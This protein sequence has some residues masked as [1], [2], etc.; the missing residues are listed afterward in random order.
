MCL[1]PWDGLVSTGRWSIC[2]CLAPSILSNR[3]Q[4]TSIDSLVLSRM[5]R[6][7]DIITSGPTVIFRSQCDCRNLT[8]LVTHSHEYVYAVSAPMP[9]SINATETNSEALSI[10]VTHRVHTHTDTAQ[11]ESFRVWTSILMSACVM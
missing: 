2:V 4:C 11:H 8:Q 10:H 1:G 3:M 6:G 9:F 5:R 7:E